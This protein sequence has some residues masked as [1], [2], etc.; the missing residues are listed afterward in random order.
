MIVGVQPKNLKAGVFEPNS[1]SARFGSKLISFSS[2]LDK[3]APM[4]SSS[5][6]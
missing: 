6:S 3:N 4:N 1:R 2:S 5:F